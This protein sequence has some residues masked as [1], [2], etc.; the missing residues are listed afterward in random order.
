[1]V[2]KFDYYFADAGQN[3][4]IHLYLPD[5]YSRSEE[6]YPVLYMFD[7]H[8]LYYDSDA[9]Y[10]K[11][12]GLREFLDGWHKKLIVAGIECSSDD[13][14][15]LHEYCPYH[16]QS[17][18]Y[19]DVH[20]R[21]DRTVRWI[22]EDLKPYIDQ[23]YRTWPFREATAIAGYS[24][25]GQISLYSVLR[26]NHIFSKAAVISPSILPAMEPFKDEIAQGEFS[27]DTRIFFSW[28]SGEGDPDM[29]YHLSESI[30]YLEKKLQEKQVQTYLYF[31]EGGCHNEGSWEIQVPTWMR[32]L[33]L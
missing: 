29:V 17:R 20:G 22:V 24:N 7:G 5:D 25:G 8:N 27:P 26:Y 30:R 2:I 10:G 4:R 9:T 15:R 31:Q 23:T 6:R 33:W 19:G 21:A 14:E 16:I 32:F 1:M 18:I 11:A 3:R 12:L 13:V 28:G